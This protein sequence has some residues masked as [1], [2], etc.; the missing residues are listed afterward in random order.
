MQGR[1]APFL[2]FF[3]TILP[4]TSHLIMNCNPFACSRS[5]RVV[6]E[7]TDVDTFLDKCWELQ[8]HIND[9]RDGRYEGRAVL[10]RDDLLRDLIRMMLWRPESPPPA[11][12]T[13][14]LN[15]LFK[16][17][18]HEREWAREGGWAAASPSNPTSS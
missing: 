3:T 10:A 16:E 14:L 8:E 1:G 7:T 17:F 6:P 11:D 15:T 9:M 18:M 12:R 2:H 4:H 13:A 5:N